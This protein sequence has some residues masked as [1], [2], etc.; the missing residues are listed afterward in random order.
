VRLDVTIHG[1][2]TPYQIRGMFEEEYQRLM[3]FLF[4]DPA[5]QPRAGLQLSVAGPALQGL[6]DHLL[7]ELRVL[8]A[9]YEPPDPRRRKVVS[10]T[11]FGREYRL[12]TEHGLAYSFATYLELVESSLAANE[13]LLFDF[14]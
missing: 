2:D 8:L 7:A 5:R 11:L 6:R 12:G 10:H 1:P 14:T 9:D 13:A 3:P 4:P